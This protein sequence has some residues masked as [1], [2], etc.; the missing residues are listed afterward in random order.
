MNLENN[1]GFEITDNKVKIQVLKRQHPISVI[2]DGCVQAKLLVPKTILCVK[3]CSL[4]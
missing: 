1:G 2:R 4:C 3:H